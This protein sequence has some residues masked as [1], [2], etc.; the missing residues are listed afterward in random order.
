MQNDTKAVL[1]G[2]VT[3]ITG[4]GAFV[5]L[6]DGN[7][8]MVH[9][10]EVSK[11]FVRDIGEYLKVGQTVEVVVV[12]T[13]R[14]GRISLSIKRAAEVKTAKSTPDGRT[15]YQ[16]NNAPP[17]EFVPMGRRRDPSADSFEDMMKKFKADSTAKQNDLKKAGEGKRSGGYPNPK[18]NRN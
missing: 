5:A 8:G 1:E 13:D 10:S 17:E 2:K 15:A 6:P 16:K 14:N 11:D 18:R 3:G 4:F 7:S 12:G 9:I